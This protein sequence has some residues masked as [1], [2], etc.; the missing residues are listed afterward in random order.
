MKKLVFMYILL[1]AVSSCSQSDENKPIENSI[2]GTWQLSE[3]TANNVDGT[4]SDWEQIENGYK[5]TFNNDFSYISEI[6][7]TDCNEISNSTYI[8]QSEEEINIL[9]ITIVC[10]N[11]SKTYTSKYSYTFE[12]SNL[13]ILNPI[14]PDCDEG[15]L[16]KYRKI[17]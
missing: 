13:L 6:Y 8:I 14:E 17:E 10:N 4:P 1:I 9:E 2:Y 3:R 11:Q 5:I 16:F 15:C 12:N 7:P